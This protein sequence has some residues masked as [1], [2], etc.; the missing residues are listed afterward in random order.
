VRPV[1]LLVHEYSSHIDVEVSKFCDGSFCIACLLICIACLLI[2]H[3]YYYSC[4]WCVSLGLLKVLGASTE[5]KH[6][7]CQSLRKIFWGFQIC[8]ACHCENVIICECTYLS[9]ESMS[10]WWEYVCSWNRN[11]LLNSKQKKKSSECTN[12]DPNNNNYL[13]NVN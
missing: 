12:I 9:I 4:A 6:L 10:Y 3:T 11:K 8:W 1:L 5:L 7:V 13:E 2:H